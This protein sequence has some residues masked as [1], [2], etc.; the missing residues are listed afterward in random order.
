M[1]NNERSGAR[2]A[3]LD[4][5]RQNDELLEILEIRIRLSTTL[6]GSKFRFWTT[7]GGPG[8]DRTD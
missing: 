4:H 7:S 2:D 3:I 6:K 5:D 8:E 1:N